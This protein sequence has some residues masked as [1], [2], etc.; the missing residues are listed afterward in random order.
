MDYIEYKVTKVS[1]RQEGDLY[2]PANAIVG[3]IRE[4][5]IGENPGWEIIYLTPVEKE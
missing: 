5:T 1:Q 2:L 3:S 4:F